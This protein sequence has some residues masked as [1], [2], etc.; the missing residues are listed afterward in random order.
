MACSVIDY[1]TEPSPFE[2]AL[3]AAEDVTDPFV[4]ELQRRA[5]CKVAGRPLRRRLRRHWPALPPNPIVPPNPVVPPNP[6]LPPSPILP[7]NPIY[8]LHPWLIPNPPPWEFAWAAGIESELALAP[9]LHDLA[10][11]AF[12]TVATA[13]R[14]FADQLEEEGGSLFDD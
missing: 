14:E 12:Q 7:P 9:E 4:K 5:R 10:A 6:I 13:L 11:D 2:Q 8:W 3:A 1:L